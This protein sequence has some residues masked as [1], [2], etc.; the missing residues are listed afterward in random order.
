VRYSDNHRLSELY[1]RVLT[2][3]TRCGCTKTRYEPGGSRTFLP[4]IRVPLETR[5]S[6]E[7]LRGD[8][9]S[10]VV[11]RTTYYHRD[12]VLDE[13]RLDQGNLRYELIYREKEHR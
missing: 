13:I 12:F 8:L 10:D 9:P 4:E 1:P 11:Q 6:I 2:F 7:Y 3:V 5:P